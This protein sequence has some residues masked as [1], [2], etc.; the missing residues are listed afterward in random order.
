MVDCY[1]DRIDENFNIK[2][3]F[4]LIPGMSLRVASQLLRTGKFTP[5]I[6]KKDFFSSRGCKVWNSNI[7]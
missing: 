4:L 6:N 3:E 2:T 5:G 7:R 1:G